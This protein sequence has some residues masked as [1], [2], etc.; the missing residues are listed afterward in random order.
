[1]IPLRNVALLELGQ[2]E[3]TEALDSYKRLSDSSE[4]LGNLAELAA[5]CS[6][7]ITKRGFVFFAGNGGSFADA[8]HMAAEL[9]GKMSRMRHPLPG[10]VLGANSSSMSA[11]GNDFGFDQVFSR[12]LVALQQPESV[13]VGFTTTGNSR[14]IVELAVSAKELG[15]KMFCF[16]GQTLGE[17][18]NHCKTIKVPSTRTERVQELQTTLGHILCLMIEEHL[19]IFPSSPKA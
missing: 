19:E 3:L 14:N 10:I 13:V 11:V 17:I 8:Q 18:D 6:N 16:T 4:I 2:A 5:L 12:E 15:L 9:T 1:L 7:A